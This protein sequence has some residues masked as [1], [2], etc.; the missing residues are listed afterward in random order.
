MWTRFGSVPSS[1]GRLP[2]R[3]LLF[4]CLEKPNNQESVQ[5]VSLRHHKL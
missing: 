5:V 1:G 4:M 2:L 3:E